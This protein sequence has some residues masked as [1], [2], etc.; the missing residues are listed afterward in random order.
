[1]DASSIQRPEECWA[2][3][4][5]CALDSYFRLLDGPL[6]PTKKVVIEPIHTRKSEPSSKK[7]K[8]VQNFDGGMGHPLILKLIN[9]LGSL[10]C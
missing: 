6:V 8:L 2:L 3:A 9:D 10:S 7:T 4:D 5:F 1:M